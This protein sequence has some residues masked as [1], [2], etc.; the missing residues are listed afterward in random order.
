M[1]LPYGADDNL[2]IMGMLNTIGVT[3]SNV[4]TSLGFVPCRVYYLDPKRDAL[5]NSKVLCNILK[6][7]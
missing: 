1:Q 5:C 4:P 7:F 6:V 3:R 2:R